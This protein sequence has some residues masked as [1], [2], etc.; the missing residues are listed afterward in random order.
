MNE[1]SKFTIAPVLIAGIGIL[2]TYLFMAKSKTKATLL[3]P[4]ANPRITSYYGNR[5]HPITKKESFHNGIDLA[6]ST[7]SAI[8]AP[9]DGVVTSMYSNDVGGI[10]MIVKHDN[11]LTTGYA[12][13]KGYAAKLNQ[14]VGVS[15]LIAYMG[16][17][18]QSTGPHLHFTVKDANGNLVDPLLYLS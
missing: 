15:Q 16:S 11:G 18:G 8:A 7:G 5:V 10:Q 4:V 3:Y 17:T 6:G 13:L 9:A 1:E 14:R 2:S 12:H